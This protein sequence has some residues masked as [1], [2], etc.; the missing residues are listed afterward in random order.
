MSLLG[1][2]IYKNGVD[3][4]KFTPISFKDF[5]EIQSSIFFNEIPQSN[6][7]VFVEKTLDGIIF[8]LVY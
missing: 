1:L 5:E 3:R 6:F 7:N 4:Y 8:H 2:Q